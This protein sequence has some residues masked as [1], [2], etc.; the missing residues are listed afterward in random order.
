MIRRRLFFLPE[1]VGIRVEVSSNVL[2]LY[3]LYVLDKS[4]KYIEKLT[5]FKFNVKFK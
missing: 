2:C 3:P 1:Y 4:N 5:N